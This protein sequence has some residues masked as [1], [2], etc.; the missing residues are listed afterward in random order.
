MLA[1]LGARRLERSKGSFLRSERVSCKLFAFFGTKNRF[2][3]YLVE[4]GLTAVECAC[5]IHTHTQREKSASRGK[6]VK[7]SRAASNSILYTILGSREKQKH[8]KR[9]CYWNWILSPLSS[10]SS[11]F[12]R[13]S[14]YLL[15]WLYI[16][17]V[18]VCRMFPTTKTTTDNKN[19][20]NPDRSI[21]YPIPQSIHVAKF[22]EAM[23][24]KCQLESNINI[25]TT[26]TTTQS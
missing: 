11:S 18:A 22:L 24:I 12:L 2:F 25:I 5:V 15:Q 17:L 10:P 19:T 26:T 13:I 6:E 4:K 23:G 20:H 8:M 3:L 7:R 1:L 14:I 16:Y 9:I 21:I